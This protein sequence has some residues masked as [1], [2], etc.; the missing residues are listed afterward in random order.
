M[1]AGIAAGRFQGSKTAPV[2]DQGVVRVVGVEFVDTAEHE[3]VVA[4]L[5]FVDDR[6]V[7]PRVD[8][9]DEGAS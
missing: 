8:V 1:S 7:E 6:A 3:G 5:E 2:I 4:G 9:I